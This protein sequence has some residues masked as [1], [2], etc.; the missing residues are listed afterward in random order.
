MINL[1]RHKNVIIGSLMKPITFDM[2]KRRTTWYLNQSDPFGDLVEMYPPS[3]ICFEIFIILI[4]KPNPIY[5]NND[6]KQQ[7]IKSLK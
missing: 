2:L 1:R 7:N 4:I 3:P 6:P 5:A